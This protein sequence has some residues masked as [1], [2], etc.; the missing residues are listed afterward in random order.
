MP[1][2]AAD[3]DKEAGGEEG[4]GKGEDKDEGDEKGPSAINNTSDRGD[5][6]KEMGTKGVLE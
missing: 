5:S 1:L 6:V 4:K 2:L 3:M